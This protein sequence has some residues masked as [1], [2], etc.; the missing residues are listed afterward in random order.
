MIEDFHAGPYE[1]EPVVPIVKRKDVGR[2]DP[3]PCKSGKK[4]KDCHIKADKL[5]TPQEMSNLL[6]IIVHKLNGITIPQAALD[7]FPE[8]KVGINITYDENKQEWNIWPAKN[9]PSI[10]VP[11]DRPVVPTRKILKMS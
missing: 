1:D 7:S 6:K 4:Y 3:C 2:N 11:S 8:D 9:K 5:L 10:L